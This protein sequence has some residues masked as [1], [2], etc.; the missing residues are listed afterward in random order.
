MQDEQNEL[1]NLATPTGVFKFANL[2]H[3][4]ILS[5][6]IRPEFARNIFKRIEIER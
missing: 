5:L 4:F 3:N 6:A 2:K 1:S